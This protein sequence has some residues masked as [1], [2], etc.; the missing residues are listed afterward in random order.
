MTKLSDS[1]PARTV[2]MMMSITIIGKIMGVLRDRLQGAEFGTHAA[3]G[4]AFAQASLL[5]RSFLDIMFAAAFSASFIPVFSNYLETKGKKEAFNLAASFICIVLLLTTAVTV[6]SIIFAQPISALFFRGE[7]HPEETLALAVTLLRYMFPLM[8][9]SGLAFSLT[10][11]LQTLGEFRIPAAM[12]IVSNGIILLYFFFFIDRFGVY[13]LAVAFLIGWGM[14]AVIQVPFLIRHK[15][16]FRP[17]FKDPGLKQIGKLALPVMMGT[18]VVPIN[19]M[20]NTSASSQL[21][22]GEFGVPSILFAHNLFAIVSGLFV[23][24]VANVIFPKFTRQVATKD[25]NAFSETVSET[26]RVL[27][28][29]LLPLTIGLMVLSQPLVHFVHYT[30]EFCETSVQITSTA[31]MYFSIGIVGYGLLIVLSRACFAMFDGK[32][33]V[34]AAVLAIIVNTVLSFT[35]VPIMEIA[36]PAFAN[37]IANTAGA[38]VLVIVLT[39]KGALKWNLPVAKD[40]IKMVI[41]A[42][43]M[44]VA[45]LFSVSQTAEIHQILQLGITAIVG[46]AV[47]LGLATVLKIKE[48]NWILRNFLQKGK[49]N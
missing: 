9:L 8:I 47:Y 46:I 24:S 32:T 18:W 43:I 49:T 20:I 7:Q 16:K 21:Y 28:F 1:R 44:L 23:L 26:F 10:G 41:T 25:Y 31:L 5:P 39:R 19:L 36:G 29:F 48:M 30:G 35:L 11:I 34:V 38:A 3:E 37:A 14:Q 45:V 27:V 17:N 22:G 12:S 33:P 13:G 40:I 42:A 15:F 2:A 6:I 4:I